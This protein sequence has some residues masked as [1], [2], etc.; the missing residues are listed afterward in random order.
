L[1]DCPSPCLTLLLAAES[2]DATTLPGIER[3]TALQDLELLGCEVQ[4]ACLLRVA[5]GMTRLSL[6]SLTLQPEHV[7]QE[8]VLG[9]SQLL[10]L[11]ARLPV[12][13]ELVLGDVDGDWPQ[14]LS[15]YSALTASSS[16][17]VLNIN[18]C[19]IHHAA[20]QHVFP[21]GRKLQHLHT[22]TTYECCTEE[23]PSFHCA[24][25]PHIIRCCPGLKSLDHGP[26]TD[27][28]LESLGAL[29][30]LTRLEL[31][32]VSQRAVGA[33][34]GLTQL[35]DLKL[36]LA[37]AADD[38]AELGL[39]DLIPLTTLTR[40]TKLSSGADDAIRVDLSSVSGASQSETAWVA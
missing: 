30:T 23:D 4:P 31:G 15:L 35:Q 36:H 40:L 27:A 10:Q 6:E 20:W 8:G 21:A 33:V 5:T 3:L 16:L 2:V 1:F 26:T 32:P 38:E 24:D 29:T 39:R 9:A 34:T 25:F 13:Q 12:L 28:Q 14:Q 18:G 17:Q 22:L 37:A 11:L 7:Q 19:D